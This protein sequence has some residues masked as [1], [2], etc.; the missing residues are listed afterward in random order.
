[1]IPKVWF[2]KVKIDKLDLIKMLCDFIK[3]IKR[4]IMDREKIFSNHISNKELV[5]RIYKEL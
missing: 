2:I 3:R 4:E 5:S 1:M